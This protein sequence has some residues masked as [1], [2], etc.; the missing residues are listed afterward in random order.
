M[1]I[2][3]VSLQLTPVSNEMKRLNL[4]LFEAMAKMI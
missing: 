3:N 4:A 2:A 1:V